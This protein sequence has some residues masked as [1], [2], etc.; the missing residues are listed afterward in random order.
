M[1]FNV[2]KLLSNSLEVSGVVAL[3]SCSLKVSEMHL[4]SDSHGYIAEVAGMSWQY[5]IL[6]CHNV[7]QVQF[8]ACPMQSKGSVLQLNQEAVLET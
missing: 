8:V 2:E 5:E 6:H 3:I 4:S 1:H 7:L